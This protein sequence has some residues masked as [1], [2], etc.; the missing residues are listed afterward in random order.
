VIYYIKN[1]IADSEFQNDQIADTQVLVDNSED[2][3]WKRLADDAW[4]Q[5]ADESK[6]SI[7]VV[8]ANNINTERLK[9]RKWNKI[10]AAGEV[11]EDGELDTVT[12]PGGTDSDDKW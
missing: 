6:P 1:T 8:T 9:L 12:V 10:E 4:T 7:S 2:D 11:A 3:S 5:V